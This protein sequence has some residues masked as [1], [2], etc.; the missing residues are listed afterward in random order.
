MRRFGQKS[1]IKLLILPALLA[2]AVCARADVTWEKSL[3]GAMKK[4]MA[5][6]KPIFVDFYAEWC[7]PCKMLEKD[8]FPDPQVQG[9]LQKTICLRIDVDQNQADAERFKVSSIPRLLLLSPDGGKVLWDAVG[10]RDAATFAEELAEALKIKLSSV[11]S[12][13]PATPVAPALAK[14]EA[15]LNGGTFDQ[16]RASDSKTA[17]AGLRLLV[18]KLGA[19]K[20]ADF[21]RIAALLGKAG[22]PA[23]PA[24]VEGM[25]SKTLAIR[26]GAHKVAQ[27]ILSKEELKG[28]P[29]D[30]WAPSKDRTAQLGAWKKLTAS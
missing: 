10:Y 2:A 4:A 16:L 22:R 30:P 13:K 7:G 11:A 5:A 14:V 27:S 3:A 17:T 9:L 19:F 26:V 20:E 25:S 28:L 12:S 6:K 29:F 23:L 8:V 24:L 18:Q 1:P 21:K 15:A